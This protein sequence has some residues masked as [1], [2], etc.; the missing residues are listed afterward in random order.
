MEPVVER[1]INLARIAHVYYTHKNIDA[2]RRF[3]ED[4]GLKE[5]K[6]IGK[7][8]YYRGYSRE[9]FVYCASEGPEASFGGAA[10]VVETIEDLQLAA[11]TL[12]GASEI[13][14][15][16]DAPGGGKCV[17]FHDPVDNFP[18]HLVHGQTPLD[19]EIILPELEFNFVGE[20]PARFQQRG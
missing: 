3:I 18:F 14:E 5:S 2:A 8:T 11:R 1:K 12:P 10:F 6:R 9:P 16:A 13:Y 17:T 4:F 20:T 15:L 19:E 7:K